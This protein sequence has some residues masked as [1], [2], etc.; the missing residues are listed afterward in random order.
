M[1][2]WSVRCFD[3]RIR[4]HLFSR[5]L[6]HLPSCWSRGYITG[7]RVAF[8]RKIMTLLRQAAWLVASCKLQTKWHPFRRIFFCVATV[9]LQYALGV[10]SATVVGA[11]SSR[12]GAPV[13]SLETDLLASWSMLCG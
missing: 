9:N 3:V 7:F 10:S 4:Y 11:R 5:L 13:G 6:K 8:I 2:G 1:V 12:V